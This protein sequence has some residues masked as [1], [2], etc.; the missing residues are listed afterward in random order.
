MGVHRP[1]KPTPP[2]AGI[3]AAYVAQAPLDSLAGLQA[4]WVD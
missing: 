1:L 3:A 2:K 4:P